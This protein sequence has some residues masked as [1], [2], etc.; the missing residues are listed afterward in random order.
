MARDCYRAIFL[1]R[2]EQPDLK[3][4]KTVGINSNVEQW[5]VR[6]AAVESDGG[7]VAAQ[8][9]LAAKAGADRNAA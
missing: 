9:W 2:W 1:L 6:K 5:N 8:H 7:V 3:E 4:E